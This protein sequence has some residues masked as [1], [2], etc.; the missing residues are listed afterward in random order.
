MLVLSLSVLSS[1]QSPKNAGTI[2][3]SDKPS[4]DA[5]LSGWKIRESNRSTAT[6]PVFYFTKD[7]EIIVTFVAGKAVGVAV[8]DRPGAGMS[9]ITPKRFEELVT[10]AGGRPS[11]KDIFRD[12]VGIRE[13]S[14]GDSD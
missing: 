12:D 5:L 14:V 3:G 11:P 13:F 2:L 7:V 6:R 4:V 9:P 10:I 1:A 8:I